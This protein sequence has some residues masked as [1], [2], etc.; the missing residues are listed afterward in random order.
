MILE[1]VKC[2]HPVLRE[3]GKP[4]AAVTAEIRQLAADMIETM[5][6]AKGV[7]LAAQQVGRALMLA[8]IDV[9]AS[10]QPSTFLVDGAL[11]NL[12]VR[13]PLVLVNPRLSNLR[14][15]QIGPEGCLSVPEVN[16][17]IKRAACVTVTAQTLDSVPLV[18][19]GTGLLAR[20]VQHEFDH[21]HGILFL[22]RMDAATRASYAGKIKKL[23]KETQAKLA[24]TVQP[25][26][27]L[28][29]R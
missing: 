1:I 26:R 23:Q 21:L 19:D 18:F 22:D 4:I 10:E 7:G 24:A 12:E 11:Q 9:T 25:R 17:D 14:G 29:H 6:A 8:V 2:G 5:Y 28:V 15:E 3:K 13:M 27:R 16:T 20:A